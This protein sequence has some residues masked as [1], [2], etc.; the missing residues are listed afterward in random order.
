MEN[1]DILTSKP[2]GNYRIVK[3]EHLRQYDRGLLTLADRTVVQMQPSDMLK[4]KPKEGDTYVANND[5][6]F[7]I[8]SA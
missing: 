3:V 2:T 8:T 5:G 1:E 4:F 7:T 6:T